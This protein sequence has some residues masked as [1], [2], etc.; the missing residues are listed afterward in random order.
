[1]EESKTE[2]KAPPFAASDLMTWI[3]MTIVDAPPENQSERV[4]R[5]RQNSKRL[6]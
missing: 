5:V 1:M 3:A 4:L 2:E 6:K